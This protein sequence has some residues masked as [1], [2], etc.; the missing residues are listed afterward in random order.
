M[1]T[2]PRWQRTYGTFG[3]DP[4]LV[5]DIMEHLIPGIQ[6]SKEGVTVDGVA[7]TIK[8]FPGGG[9]REN[10]FDPHY[11]QGQWNVYATPDSL[12]K[13]HLPAF[14]KAVECKAASIMPYYAKPAAAKSAVQHAPDGTEIPMQAV[15]FAYNQYFIQELLKNR[16]GFQ[17]YINSDS[18]ITIN[19]AWGVEALDTPERI[20]LAVN[21]GIDLIS[22]SFDVAAAGTA[23]Q[24]GSLHPEALCRAVTNT[25]EEMFALG[26]MDNPYRD[27]ENAVQVV[28]DFSDWNTAYRVHQQSV[29][30]LK[31]LPGK[32]LPEGCRLYVEGLKADRSRAAALTE[33][34]REIA[35]ED[36][37][38]TLASTPEEADAVFL[39][40]EP[41]S[42]EYFNA[43][44]GYL[45]LDLCDGKM[46]CDVDESG[47]PAPSTH[48]E[49]TLA[50]VQRIR[51]LAFQMHSNGGTLIVGVN[52]TL[53]WMLGNVEPFAD[54]LLA[55]FDTY[56]QAMLDVLTGRFRSCGRLP[57]TLPRNDAVLAVNTQGVCI[58]PND[59]PGYDKDLYLPDALKDENGKAYA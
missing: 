31:D 13:Y 4:K 37:D 14:A 6:G 7:V 35:A 9:A 22:G 30:K 24:R 5:C 12:E 27:A 56:P 18:G 52:F 43:T 42:G 28:S 59:V 19:M 3:E 10:G 58:S 1:V 48:T 44:M 11:A 33:H 46:V 40:C 49:C 26:V 55:G 32:P 21:N 23:C 45:E 51:E 2:D 15:G 36:P 34:L 57:F 16:M 39:Y 25:L 29:V 17:G 47:C 41:A 8:H 54:V 20:A 50:D 38:L 53:A